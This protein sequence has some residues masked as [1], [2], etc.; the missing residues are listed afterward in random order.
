[1]LPL[2]FDST[3][4]FI[5]LSNLTDTGDSPRQGVY[6]STIPTAWH[7]KLGHGRTLARNVNV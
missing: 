5:V 4:H 2:P 3:F 6:N 1:M 7:G